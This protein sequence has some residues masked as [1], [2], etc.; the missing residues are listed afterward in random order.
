MEVYINSENLNFEYIILNG[1]EPFARGTFDNNQV[2][3]GDVFTVKLKDPCPNGSG[4]FATASGGRF[5]IKSNV[6]NKNLG[7]EFP[8]QCISEARGEKFPDVSPVIEIVKRYSVITFIP[9]CFG[10]NGGLSFSKKIKDP[11]II[12]FV[13]NH[14][15]DFNFRIGEFNISLKIRT[16]FTNDKIAELTREI[17][18]SLTGF[19]S[20]KLD[21]ISYIKQKY[22]IIDFDV[23]K[24]SEK[25][26]PLVFFNDCVNAEKLMKRV[27]YLK[28]GGWITVEKTEAM[29]VIDVNS[30]S[31]KLSNY[32][33]NIEAAG[34]ISEVL[35]YRDITGIIM[36][37]FINMKKNENT[38]L[39][40]YFREKM[41]GDY[42][43]FEISGFTKLGVLELQRRR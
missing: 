4:Y 41:S 31:S 19:T 24:T 13:K 27:V 38:E 40:S 42:A 16:E 6:Y 18:E 28:S 14:F 35:R 20:R 36:I 26:N 15:A 29:T 25:H 2:H 8:V 30:G 1:G 12:N 33:L 34:K 17:N 9:E 5:F 23:V 11:D 7:K 37:D 21:F 22:N 3:K 32:D 10:D 39:I 43:Y